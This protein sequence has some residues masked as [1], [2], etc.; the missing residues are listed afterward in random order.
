M[1]LLAARSVLAD[2][3]HEQWMKYV[4][5]ANVSRRSG[6][7]AEAQAAFERALKPAAELAARGDNLVVPATHSHLADL[8]AVTGRLDRCEWHALEGL[9]ALEG[10][11]G[12]KKL[13]IEG[14]L[15]MLLGIALY[16]T[17]REP[18]GESEFLRAVVAYRQAEGLDPSELA[19][20]IV[21]VA[22]VRLEQR[23]LGEAENLMLEV[24]EMH[25]P[26]NGRKTP[27]L[28]FAHEGIGVLRVQAG[29]FSEG[30]R[31]LGLAIEILT[32]LYGPMAPETAHILKIRAH[33][34]TKLKRKKEAQ[35][36]TRHAEAI[37]ESMGPNWR[38]STVSI[39]T[40]RG[41]K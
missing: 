29:K 19:L 37:R 40:L 16:R 2:T 28:A 20:A 24:L 22:T 30:E 38:G 39:H 15:R 6:A 11:T 1:A 7:V 14:K 5:E 31:E 9:R 3:A 10:L 41:R 25:K 13:P 26:L 17:G 32:A 18:A 12:L 27:S 4:N 36:L 33:A 34:L 21:N 35:Q 8:H 23:R